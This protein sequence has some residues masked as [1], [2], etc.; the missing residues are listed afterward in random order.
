MRAVSESVSV[1]GQSSCTWDVGFNDV[2]L[3]SHRITGLV[4]FFFFFS[5]FFSF[6]SF[7]SRVVQQATKSLLCV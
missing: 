3:K 4:S 7:F 5:F 6:L 1:K 2:A